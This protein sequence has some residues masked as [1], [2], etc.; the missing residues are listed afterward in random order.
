MQNSEQIKLIG[1]RKKVNLY[2]FLKS[3]HFLRNLYL[4][5]SKR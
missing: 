1:K 2:K 3:K 4:N 5:K